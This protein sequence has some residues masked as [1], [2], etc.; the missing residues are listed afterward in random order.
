MNTGILAL[1]AAAAGAHLWAVLRGKRRFRRI[2]KV[3]LMPLLTFYYAVQAERL[4]FPVILG[5]VFGWAGD[6]LL[7]R[8]SRLRY[9]RLGL[10][11]FLLGH[12]CYILSMLYLAGSFHL[13]GLV[14]SAIA[15]LPLG[16][17]TL[18]WVKP[19]RD[20][21]IP[22]ILYGIILELMSLSA[23]QLALARMDLWGNIV[24]GG[25][26]LF[27]ISDSILGYLSFRNTTRLGSFFVMATYIAA[28]SCVIIALTRC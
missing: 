21:R 7:I 23:L 4:L 24:F 5:A 3:I 27:L 13:P 25:S 17:L 14:V 9:F 26:L 16:I 28:Q 1:F 8:I 10:A 20:M 15:A 19:N 22:V 2:S 18:R 6:I 11:S 12:L